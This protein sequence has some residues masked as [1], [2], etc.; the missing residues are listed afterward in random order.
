V[1]RIVVDDREPDGGVPVQLRLV[2]V[3]VVRGRLEAGDARTSVEA[4]SWNGR[5]SPIFT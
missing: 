3:D 1:C 4:S 2:G 5:V